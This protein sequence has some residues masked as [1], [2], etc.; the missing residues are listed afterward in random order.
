MKKSGQRLKENDVGPFCLSPVRAMG[1]KSLAAVKTKNFGPRL[2]NQLALENQELEAAF[3]RINRQSL[4]P[5]A[6]P[7]QPLPQGAHRADGAKHCEGDE[8]IG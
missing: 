4:M 3:C 5:S 7:V 2:I 1:A 8:V 6:S